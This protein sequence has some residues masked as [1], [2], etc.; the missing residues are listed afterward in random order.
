MPSFW[1]NIRFSGER[2][3]DGLAGGAGAG[4]GDLCQPSGAVGG[5]QLSRG[6]RGDGGVWRHPAHRAGVR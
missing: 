2:E 5:Q 6:Y 3:M 1:E 4:Y